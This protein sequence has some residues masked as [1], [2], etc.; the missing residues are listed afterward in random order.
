MDPALPTGASVV[1][2]D[3]SPL[4]LFNDAG[5]LTELCTW[6]DQGAC[7]TAQVVVEIELTKSLT[8]FPDNK[9]IIDAPWLRAAPVEDDDLRL[10]AGLRTLWGSPKGRDFGEAEVVALCKRYGW[11]AIINDG[12]GRHAA[13]QNGVPFVSTAGL[14]V[15][16]AAHHAISRDHGWELHRRIEG[17]FTQPMILPTDGEF[18]PAFERAVSAV[19]RWMSA[20][21]DVYW[22]ATIAMTPAID[23]VLGRAV[24]YVRA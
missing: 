24:A 8:K 5:A 19:E 1:C 13:R 12:R 2:F 20:H 23:D 9:A 15:G 14:L 16:A 22:P 3:A 10:V 6:F 18:R 7:F 17:R 4:I 21:E 11:T